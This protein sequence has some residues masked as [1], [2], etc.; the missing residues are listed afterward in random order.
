MSDKLDLVIRKLKE[1]TA[2][3]QLKW[4]D[5]STLVSGDK[6]RV[7]F[8]DTVV[9]VSAEEVPLVDDQGDEYTGTVYTVRVLNSKA[10]VVAERRVYPMSP[11]RQQAEELFEVARAKARNQDAVLDSLLTR[12]G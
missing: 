3:G 12:L 8:G 6:F 11:G 5:A 9:E 1:Q 7:N 4:E 10:M 2:S